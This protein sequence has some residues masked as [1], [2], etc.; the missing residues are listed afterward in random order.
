VL[1]R[2]RA[3]D[4]DVLRFHIRLS[5]WQKLRVLGSAVVGASMP[6]EF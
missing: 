2:I 4:H 3:V 6:S 1:A 5:R